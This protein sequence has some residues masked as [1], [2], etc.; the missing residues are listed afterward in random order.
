MITTAAVQSEDGFFGP[1]APLKARLG[2]AFANR[3]AFRQTCAE[4]R[5]LSDRQLGDLG[6][7]RDRIES[8]AA[9]R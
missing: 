3:R 2:R 8:A 4:L 6:L 5:A 9:A 7:T 1:M